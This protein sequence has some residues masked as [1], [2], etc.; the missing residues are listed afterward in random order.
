MPALASK[1]DQ[2]AMV[3]KQELPHLQEETTQ[4]E[5]EME[6]MKAGQRAARR[7]L[8]GWWKGIMLV[9]GPPIA[10]LVR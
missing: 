6:K 2:L 8:L 5:V 1:L 4:E 7:V 3:Q 9:A 10:A